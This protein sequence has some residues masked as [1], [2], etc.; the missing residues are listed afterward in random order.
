[1]NE[2]VEITAHPSSQSGHRRKTVLGA[3]VVLVAMGGA[4]FAYWTATGTGTSTNTTTGDV[5]A[6][7]VKQ[8]S[9][10]SGLAPG[11]VAAAL[12]GNFDNPNDAA[13]ALTSVTGAVTGTS[14]SG[15][16]AT[17]YEVAGTGTVSGGSVPVGTGVGSWSGLTIRLVNDLALNQDPCKNATVTITYT[18]S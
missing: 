6:V 7:T 11:A 15:C 12:S 17:W 18:A 14:D 10:I 1:M 9:V 3:T 16:L 13:V 8:T 5:K 2:R 4:A